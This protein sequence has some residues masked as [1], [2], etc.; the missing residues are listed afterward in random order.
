MAG[1]YNNNQP[2]NIS[3]Y[4]LYYDIN[5]ENLQMYIPNDYSYYDMNNTNKRKFLNI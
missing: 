4:K 5:D 1:N 3:L 2:L